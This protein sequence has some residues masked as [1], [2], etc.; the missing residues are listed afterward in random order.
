MITL[1]KADGSTKVIEKAAS[2]F[3]LPYTALFESSFLEGVLKARFM[4]DRGAET[5]F[6][7]AKMLEKMLIIARDKQVMTIRLRLLYTGI[8][9]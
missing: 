6:V 2:K 8:A 9:R 3:K 7:P 4:A 1:H 5:I